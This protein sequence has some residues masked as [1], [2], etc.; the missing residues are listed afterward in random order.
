M[1]VQRMWSGFCATILLLSLANPAFALRDPKPD[2]SIFDPPTDGGKFF[3]VHDAENLLK[4][5]WNAG[6]YLEYGRKPL[7]LRNVA[8]ATRFDIVRDNVTGHLAG[9]YGITDWMSVGLSVP[10]TMFQ[11]FFDPNTQLLSLGNAPAQHKSGIGDLR[12]ETKFRLLDVE[13][14]NFGIA[15]IPNLIFPTGRTGSFISGERWLPGLTVAFEGQPSDRVALG[16]NVGY[17]YTHG[18][19]QYFAGNADAFIDDTL[20]IGIG[21][22][23]KV[24]DE[25][26]FLGEGLSETLARSPYK[27]TTQSPITLHGGVQYTPQNGWA[28]G[29]AVTM[30]GGGGITR[31]VGAPMASAILG[32]SYPNPKIVNAAPRVQAHIEEK[33]VII[34]KVHFE[35]NSSV[36]R[37]ISYPILDEVASVIQSNPSMRTVQVEGHTDDVGGDAY[38]QR[39][40]ESRARSVVN[41]LIKKGVDATRMTSRGFG[42]SRPIADNATV[43][44]R[45][46]NRRTEFTIMN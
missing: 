40:S 19:N 38:N 41:Y 3:G 21:A 24:T 6:F 46:K 35:F 34:Q 18:S 26:A 2:Q 22:R 28:R 42:E 7:Q 4:G 39:L 37:P 30:M 16:L 36:I 14:Y 23:V 17:Q 43:E 20:R 13:R 1:N 9:A 33:I 12:M 29:L 15:V 11:T 25:W 45:A 32:V 44:G 31:G 27:V 8:T 10:V 5:R